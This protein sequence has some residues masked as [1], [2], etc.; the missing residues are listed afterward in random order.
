M[1][2]ILLTGGGSGGHVYPLLAV[3]DSIRKIMHS[4]GAEAD[5]EL[6]YIGPKKDPYADLISEKGIKVYRI[7]AGKM[8]RYVS[9]ILDNLLDVPRFCLGLVQA[10]WKMFWLMPDAVFSKG[11]TGALPVVLAAWFYRVPVVIHDSDAVPGLTNLLSGRFATRIAVS[12]EAAKK[13]FN[14]SKTIVTGNPIRGELLEK[15]FPPATAKEILGFNKDAPLILVLGGSQGAQRIND[16]IILALKDIL[17]ETQILHQTGRANYMEVKNLSQAALLSIPT[18]T[19]TASRYKAVPYLEEDLAI[20][21][22]AADVVVAR[23]GS[24][25]IFEIAAF[26]KPAILIPLYEAANDHQRANAYEF[27]ETGAAVVIE[28]QNLQPSIFLHELRD[29]LSNPEKAEKMS[30][31]AAAFFQPQAAETLAKEVLALIK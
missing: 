19:E 28:E 8:R 17:A 25:S 22:S 6:V 29:I 3:A 15:K 14:P 30:K 7:S 18:R 13:Y 31:A 1:I 16:F 12:F 4:G 27:A 26:G 5:L 10:F 9:G 11:G 2:R 24:S 21:F 23:A 20:A